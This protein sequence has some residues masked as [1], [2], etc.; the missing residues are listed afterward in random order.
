MGFEAA[1]IASQ[2]GGTAPSESLEGTAN[3]PSK[4]SSKTVSRIPSS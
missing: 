2:E 4:T 1:T 3:I